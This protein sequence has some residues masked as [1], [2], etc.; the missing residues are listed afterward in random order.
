MNSKQ[1][2][3]TLA[4]TM[5]GAAALFGAALISFWRQVSR[6]CELRRFGLRRR[7]AQA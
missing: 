2:A 5:I 1:P 7:A 6:P 3:R 4:V